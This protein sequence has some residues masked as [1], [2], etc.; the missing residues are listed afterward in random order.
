MPGIVG[1]Y[2]YR[3]MRH[4]VVSSLFEKKLVVM[5]ILW[6]GQIFQLEKV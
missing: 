1:K 3:T 5:I 2:L 6:F 4:A